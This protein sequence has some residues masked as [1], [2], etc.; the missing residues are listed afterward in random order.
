MAVLNRLFVVLLGLALAAAGVIL[1][2]ETIAAAAGQPSLLVDRST[3][4]TGLSE[5]SWTDVEVDIALAV[6]IVLGGLLLLL[7]L[8]PR[9]PES[10]PLRSGQGRQAEVE[11]KAL[12]ALIAARAAN[13]RDVLDA[14]AAVTRSAAKVDARAVPGVDTRAVRDRLGQMVTETLQPLELTRSLRPRVAVRR[15]RERSA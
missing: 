15:T 13:D 12:A 6:L 3:V 2:A 11:R 10:L 8:V 4:G 14:R 5:L 7:Q 1:V 9:Q